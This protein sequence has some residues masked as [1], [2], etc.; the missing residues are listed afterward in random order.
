MAQDHD[1]EIPGPHMPETP[2]A[3]QM[4]YIGAGISL[5]VIFG[6]GVGLILGQFLFENFVFGMP[7]GI[8]VGVA[9]GVGAGLLRAAAHPTQPDT[10]STR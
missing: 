9:V 1:D 5:G 2:E 7:I 4:R 8:V 10:D 6:A 3:R